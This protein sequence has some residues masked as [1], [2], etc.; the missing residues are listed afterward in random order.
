[1]SKHQSIFRI[2]TVSWLVLALALA[3][4]SANT[5]TSTANS[6]GVVSSVTVTDKIETSGNLGAGQLVQLTW[7]TS[8]LIETVNVK[9]GQKVKTNDV[10]A[11]LKGDSVSSDIINSE[12]D[13]AQAKRD[14]DDLQNSNLSAAEAQQAFLAAK[15]DVEEAQNVMDG[16]AYPRASD[17]LIK[18]TQAKIWEAQKTLTLANKKYKEEQHNPDGDP[19][20]TAALL[21]LTNAQ[22]A[23]NELNATYNWYLAKATQADYAEAKA[24]LDVARAN[25]ETARRKRDNVKNG[26]DPFTITAAQ[27]KV[28]A[29]QAEVNAM[30]VIAPFDGEVIAVQAAPADAVKVGDNAVALVDRNTL[31]VE[32]QIDE[33]SISSVSIGNPAQVTIDSLPDTVLTGKVTLINPIGAT[34][35]GLVKY[36]VVVSIEPT[37]KPLLFGATATV[38]IQTGEPHSTLA[39]PVSAVQ[40]STQGEYVTV[41]KANGDTQRVVVVSGD[42]IDTLVTITL[43]TAGSLA[44]GDKVELGASSSSSGNNSNQGGGGG[45]IV[46]G[47]GGPP[48]G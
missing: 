44:E 8:G 35:N 9:V 4:C 6:V 45:G 39:V 28:D 11:S 33:T 27:A 47:A 25:L 29:A 23:L 42:L 5:A 37:A 40:S 48:G 46:P 20:K 21:A 2:F 22:L 3:G 19:E 14:L 18:N 32:T 34:V 30:L 41:I 12:S 38:V 10:L 26:V 13:L 16:L 15:K 31:K 36:T 1:M 17:A 24:N 7:G 43:P